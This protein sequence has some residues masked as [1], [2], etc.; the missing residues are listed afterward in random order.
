M[1]NK[2]FS[3]EIVKV[4]ADA[5]GDI[6]SHVVYVGGAI[7]GVYADDPAA[8]DVRPT[9]DVDITLKIATYAEL[10]KLEQ[11]L[12][13][14]GFKRDPLEK[15]E[16]R[17]FLNEILIDVMSTTRVGWAP[18]NSWFEPGFNHLQEFNLE[19]IIIKILPLAYFL[20]TK[21]EAFND[22]GRTDPRTSRDLED[23]VYILDN[24]MN[25]INDMLTA[26]GDVKNYLINQF[27]MLLND[28]ILQEAM[29]GNL[30]YETQSERQKI[31]NKKLLEIIDGV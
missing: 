15:V 5:L 20:A 9:K 3:L 19:G 27:K 31:I 23:I 12:L 2:N 8:D 25:L 10:S 29:L 18:A 13:K 16:C 30:S 4:V 28:S 22:R 6:N 11:E 17:F 26:P 14:K 24:R 7:V 21:F 1:K